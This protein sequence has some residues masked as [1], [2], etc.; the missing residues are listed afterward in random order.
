M[1]DG[2]RRW[3]AVKK[4]YSPPVNRR[5]GKPLSS[6]LTPGTE[7]GWGEQAAGPEPN[8]NI[9]DHYRFVVFKDPMWDWKT[10]DFDK[11]L[12]RSDSPESLV[13]NATDPNI[14]P[15]F[16]HGGKL[17]IY[18][19]WSDPRVPALQTI[20]YYKRVV[21]AIG[22]SVEGVEQRPAVRGA[23]HGSLWRRRRTE[24]VRQGRS[25]GAVGGAGQAAG[26][27]SSPH[28]VTAGKVDRTRPLC[29]YPQIAKYTGHGQH[30]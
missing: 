13:M 17:L 7:L 20:E 6:P 1:P 25:A 5:T 10:F 9:N 16:S 22:G 30:R 24:C 2:R 14:Q 27:R 21:D 12:A 15:F 8:A 23:W 19:G 28:I 18:Q 26:P 11:D 3:T 29:P 4:M